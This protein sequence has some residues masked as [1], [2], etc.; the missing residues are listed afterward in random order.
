M[1]EV[2]RREFIAVAVAGTALRPATGGAPAAPHRMTLDL[3]PWAIGIEASQLEVVELAA[4]HGFDSVA[5]LGKELRAMSDPE[6]AALRDLMGERGVAWGAAGLPVDF[7]KDDETFARTSEG[8][9]DYARGLRRAGVTRVGT[10]LTPCSDS[11]T[12]RRYF[13]A[14]VGRLAPTA[15]LLAGE[16]VRLGLEYVAPR[17]SWTSCRYPF[18]HTFAETAELVAAIGVPGVG[19]V[20][21]SWH[22]FLAGDTAA[23]ILSLQS[24]DVVAVDLNDAPLGIPKH[25]QKDLERELPAATGVIPV[26]DFLG[27]L[28]EI[29]YDGPVR[30]EP[31]SAPLDALG[32]DEAAAATIAALRKAF[33]TL[34]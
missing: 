18:V 6:L 17:T 30:A 10:W 32:N 8:L 5:P 31:F 7:R 24:A 1:P 13:D 28:R 11:Y 16:G 15:R 14:V 20:L 9:A 27:A 2:N 33:A 21:D 26:G 29:G 22:W 34:G 12:Y 23:D 4:R 25:E 3:T 19:Y